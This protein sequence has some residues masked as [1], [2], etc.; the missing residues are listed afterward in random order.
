MT[1]NHTSEI[2][3]ADREQ[4]KRPHRGENQIVECSLEHLNDKMQTLVQRN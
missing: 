1:C 2:K 4:C 3:Q